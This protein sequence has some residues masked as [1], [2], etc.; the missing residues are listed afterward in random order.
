MPVALNH[1]AA[2]AY[3]GDVYVLG[4]YTGRGDLRGEVASLYRYDP[5]ARP[6]VAG[7]RTRP[8]AAPRWRSA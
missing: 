7:C 1:P 4:G 3:R 8:R 5:R 2:A 6:V